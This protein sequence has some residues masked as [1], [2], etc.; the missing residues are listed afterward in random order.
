MFVQNC[1]CAGK[2]LN[3]HSLLCF[4]KWRKAKTFIIV[5]DYFICL[6]ILDKCYAIAG[7]EFVPMLTHHEFV[8]A[9][10]DNEFTAIFCFAY[11]ERLVPRYSFL[12]KLLELQWMMITVHLMCLFQLDAES[13]GRLVESLS[14]SGR[15]L[16]I[17]L[18]FLE[19][20]SLNILII[21]ALALKRL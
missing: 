3:K 15:K 21:F 7:Y 1:G 5:N 4:I 2:C 9:V 10:V 14:L 18:A 12:F 16:L 20:K 13:R 19:H 17:S 6:S 8:S 11:N